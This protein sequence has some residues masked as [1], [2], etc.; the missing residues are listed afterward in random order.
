MSKST[1][2]ILELGDFT[3]EA[4]GFN[5]RGAFLLE[6]ATYFMWRRGAF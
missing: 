1:V 3:E 6:D 5:W 2:T 4:G